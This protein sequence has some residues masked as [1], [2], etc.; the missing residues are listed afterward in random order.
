MIKKLKATVAL[1]MSLLVFSCGPSPVMAEDKVTNHFERAEVTRVVDG[2]TVDM[3]IELGFGL[4][5]HDRFRLYGIDTPE[6]GKAGN[7]E[8]TAN[9]KRL[10][11]GKTVSFDY[12]KKDKYGR[13]L[14]TIY[15]LVDGKLYDVN[16]LMVQ[17][18]HAKPYFG[19]KKEE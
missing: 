3:R 18:G 19:G 13:H 11:E 12:Y 8:A 7:T 14:A 6:K 10:I 2:D 17:H 16:F 15:V 9:L 4:N 1:A 5:M